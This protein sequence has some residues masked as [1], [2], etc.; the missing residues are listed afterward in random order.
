[1]STPAPLLAEVV[2]WDA[3]TGLILEPIQTWNSAVVVGKRR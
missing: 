1:M 2:W 3:W